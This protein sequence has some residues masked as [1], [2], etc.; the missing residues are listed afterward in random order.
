[1]PHYVFPI[2]FMGVFLDIHDGSVN[3]I[4]T[5]GRR[6]MLASY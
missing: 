1:M 3:H 2:S 5:L 4:S 6:N